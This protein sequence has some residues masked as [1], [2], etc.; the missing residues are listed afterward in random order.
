MKAIHNQSADIKIDYLLLLIMQR[1][2]FE[3]NSQQ[4]QTGVKKYLVGVHFNN[5][6]NEIEILSIRGI[7]PKDTAHWLNWITQ[8]KLIYI[9]KEKI[10][11]LI[12]QQQ[13][14]LADLEYLDLDSVAKIIENFENPI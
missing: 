7:F 11:T 12:D 3:S 4:K 2:N 13:T 10:Q 1:Y 8:G 9:N 14:N 6:R 5:K